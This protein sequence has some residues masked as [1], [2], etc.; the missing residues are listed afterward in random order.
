MLDCF[1]QYVLDCLW[2]RNLCLPIQRPLV[3][4]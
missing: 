3:E 4:S 2:N 1:E